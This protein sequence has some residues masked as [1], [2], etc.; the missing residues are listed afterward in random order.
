MEKSS[1]QKFVDCNN[2]IL[3]LALSL[4]VLCTPIICHNRHGDGISGT[5]RVP[6]GCYSPSIPVL[7]CHDVIDE[8]LLQMPDTVQE[9]IFINSSFS[10][11]DASHLQSLSWTHSDLVNAT[12]HIIA[13]FSLISLDVSHNSIRNLTH[14]QFKDYNK[15]IS[16]NLSNNQINDLPRSVFN[17]CHSLQFLNISHN[18]L[19]VIPFQVFSPLQLL[20]VLDLSHNSLEALLDHFFKLNRQVQILLLNDNRIFKLTS[21]ALA[22]LADLKKLDLSNNALSAISKGLF[23]SLNGLEELDLSNNPLH[24]LGSGTFRGLHSLRTLNLSGNKLRYLTYGLF[25]FSQRMTHLTLDNT[26]IEVLHNTELFGLP[27]LQ[28]LQMRNNHML[29]EIEAYALADTSQLR[30]INISGNALSFLPLSLANLTEL[31]TLDISNNPWACDCRMFWFA[32]WTQERKY[33]NPVALSDLSC[34]PFTY[35]ND[36]IPTLQHLNCTGPLIVYKTPTTKYRLKSNALLE[37]RYM[38]NPPPSITWVTPTRE[39]FH[40][41]PDTNV[42]DIF[43]KHPYA[44]DSK[45]LPMKDLMPRIQVLDNGTLFIKDVRRTDC[46]RYTCYASNPVANMTL[47]VLLH[48]DPVDWNRIRIMSLIVGAECAAI[49][50]IVTVVVQLIR[51]LLEKLGILD[52]CCS[53]CKRDRVSPRAKQIYALLDNIEQYKSQQLERLRENYTMQV[54]RIRDNCAQQVEW[55]Q[56]SYQSQAK[57]LKDF[58]DIGTQHLSTLREQYNDQVK[59][60]RD[61]STGQLNWVRENYIFQRNKIRKFS[62]HKV[63][64]LRET[65]KYQQQTLNRVLENLPSLYL[66]N[67][68]AGTCGKEESIVFDPNDIDSIDMYIKSKIDRL[69]MIEDPETVNARHALTMISNDDHTSISRQSLYYTPTERSVLGSQ[70]SLDHTALAGVHINYIENP[71]P[72]LP[73]TDFRLFAELERYRCEDRLH[74]TK[75]TQDLRRLSAESNVDNGEGE[76][77]ASLSNHEESAVK[78][79]ASHSS[80]LPD[81]SSTVNN[82]DKV[83]I[84]QLEPFRE[85]ASIKMNDSR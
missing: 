49:F 21:N 36:M 15:L 74:S 7:Y 58:R 70:R 67:C 3:V 11:L 80:S 76:A 12:G 1:R 68:R 26:L 32:S 65:Y 83:E 27:R 64:Q 22:D 62:A 69:T 35:P 84:I 29:Q 85:K 77:A 44:H 2:W 16:L 41:N 38:A 79:L 40:W 82:S 75:S 43:H 4:T 50:L 51:M 59:K 78:L 54:A 42:P 63:L 66:E 37:C 13:P 14:Y 28:Y 5:S 71:S 47:D 25:H 48:I 61:Y 33:K 6:S 30:S 45:L 19:H 46:G 10:H 18:H 81:L 24:I 34:G 8:R 73:G 31:D 55:I 57:H 60:V 56:G 17:N 23:D 9:A 39:V 52:H 72:L 20:H 53:F